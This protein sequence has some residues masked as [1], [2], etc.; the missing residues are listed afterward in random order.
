[1]DAAFMS[2]ERNAPQPRVP[3]PGRGADA[4]SGISHDS[5]IYNVLPLCLG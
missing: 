3:G 5:T 4:K 2:L 1:M